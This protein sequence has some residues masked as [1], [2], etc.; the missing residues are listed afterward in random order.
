MK[1]FL[2]LWPNRTQSI[3]TASSQEQ[4]SDT[5]DEVG[6]PGLARCAKLPSTGGYIYSVNGYQEGDAIKYLKFYPGHIAF[7]PKK[8]VL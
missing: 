4:L 1:T 5:L 7:S 8:D 2:V 6:D 3:V